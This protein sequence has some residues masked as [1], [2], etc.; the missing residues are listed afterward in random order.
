MLASIFNRMMLAPM[1]A[2]SRVPGLLWLTLFASHCLM[3][4]AAAVWLVA[5]FALWKGLGLGWTALW[6]LPTCVAVFS[7]AYT[8]KGGG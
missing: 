6:V 7:A 2:T 8:P 4:C 1:L 5:P 3:L